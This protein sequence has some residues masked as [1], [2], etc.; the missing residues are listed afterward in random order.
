MLSQIEIKLLKK[1]CESELINKSELREFLKNQTTSDI[2]AVIDTALQRLANRGFVTTINI[3]G[4]TSFAIT[5][6]GVQMIE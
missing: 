3:V 5:N 6:K 2:N 4:S 1:I